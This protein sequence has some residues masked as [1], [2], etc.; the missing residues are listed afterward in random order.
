MIK[1]ILSLEGIIY[2]KE[3]NTFRT[4]SVNKAIELIA[5]LSSTSD[6]KKERQ[7]NINSDPSPSVA[8]AGVEPATFGL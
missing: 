7:A 5:A 1:N 8:R 6:L 3:N 2:D 4:P